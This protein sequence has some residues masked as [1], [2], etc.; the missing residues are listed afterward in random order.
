ML[1]HDRVYLRPQAV[2]ASPCAAPDSPAQAALD[3]WLGAN[4]PFVAARQAASGDRLALGLCLPLAHERRRL[5]L[6]VAAGDIAAVLPPLGIDDCLDSLDA[7]DRSA[8]QSLQE[9]LAR[10]G[11][12]VGVYGSLA[13]Q[14]S[15]GEAYRRAGSDIDL[16]VD[17]DRRDQ[18]A[19]ALAALL[20]AD[21]RAASR[22]DGELR[23]AGDLAVAW[24]ELLPML[25]G[26]LAGKVLAKGERQVGLFAI[27]ELLAGLSPA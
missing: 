3:A 9:T 2:V 23:F 12:R 16:I 6:Q 20:E 19:A 10:C 7:V 17:V 5:S 21:R 1:R 15:S 25:V 4:R 26:D 24:R 11:A 8:L 22:I 13:W 27:G 18:C 14:T